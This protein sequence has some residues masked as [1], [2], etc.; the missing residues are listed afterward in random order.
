MRVKSVPALRLE[1]FSKVQVLIYLSPNPS[2]LCPRSLD[3]QFETSWEAAEQYTHISRASIQLA[4]DR[5]V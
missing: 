2:S 3:I 4:D 1:R 5:T